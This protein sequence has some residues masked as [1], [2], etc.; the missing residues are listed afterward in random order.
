MVA[1]LLTVEMP[2]AAN[3]HLTFRLVYAGDPSIPA[4]AL[5]EVA[6]GEDGSLFLY[7]IGGTDNNDGGQLAGFLSISPDG[8][9]A[10]IEPSRNPFSNSDPGS[11]AHLGSRPGTSTPWLMFIDPDGV[12]V[13]T[14]TPTSGD[15]G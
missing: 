15:Q 2:D 13:F 1:D 4:Y 9:A 7:L 11:P 8:V 6:S 3:R 14:R 10:P 12:R 5:V